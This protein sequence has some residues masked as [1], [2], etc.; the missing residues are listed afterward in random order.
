[1]SQQIN[2][3]NPIF[4][5]QK[6]YFSVT[7]MA[8]AL[9]LILL[10]SIALAAFAFYQSSKLN[11]QAA[12]TSMQ[13]GLAQ[14]QL[15]KF[16]AE[17]VP[18]QTS[19]AVEENIQKT[20]EDVKVARQVLATLQKG[21]LGNTKGYAEYLRAFARQQVDGLW[22]TGFKIDG[23]GSAI[24]LQGRALQPELV[25]VYITR[26]KREAVMQGKSFATLEMLV[27]Q[28]L[29]ASTASP[30]EPGSK[31]MAPR[32]GQL[33]AAGYIEFNLQSSAQTPEST[34]ATSGAKN[35]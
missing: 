20:E 5:K 27:P 29:A 9:G 28:V 22:L 15:A 4:L 2:L 35:K 25:P 26:L 12:T 7:A 32:P 13:L 18:R 24:G 33:A 21:E 31:G 34:S 14:A 8:Q 6:K 1:M 3:F 10:G 16:N 19:K 30:V 23:A 17:F 11:A